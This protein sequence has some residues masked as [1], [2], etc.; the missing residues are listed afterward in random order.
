MDAGAVPSKKACA[1][2]KPAT[3]TQ[4]RRSGKSSVSHAK[5]P[6]NP[7]NRPT[8]SSAPQARG[9]FDNRD[10]DVEVTWDHLTKQSVARLE[11]SPTSRRRRQLEILCRSVG[12]YLLGHVLESAPSNAPPLP[13]VSEITMKS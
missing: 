2:L 4:A 3:A 8:N 9:L 6:Y 10:L 12:M 1:N 7:R 11:A 5:E 13:Q